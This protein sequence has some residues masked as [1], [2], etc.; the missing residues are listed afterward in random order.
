MTKSQKEAAGAIVMGVGLA[1]MLV[2]GCSSSDS[3]SCDTTEDCFANETCADGSCQIIEDSQSVNNGEGNQSTNYGSSA[4][5]S[6][7]TGNDDPSTGNNTDDAGIDDS[8]TDSSSND[9][10]SADTSTEND[11]NQENDDQ[12]QCL[13][14]PGCDRIVDSAVTSAG[15][16]IFAPDHENDAVTNYGCPNEVDDVDFVGG[17]P[18]PVEAHTCSDNLHLYRL[19]TEQCNDRGFAVDIK[20]SPLEEACPVDE[21]ATISFMTGVSLAAEECDSSNTD[22]CYVIEDAPDGSQRWTIYFEEEWQDAKYRP[23]DIRVV[24]ND[25]Y[26]FPY[27]MTIDVHEG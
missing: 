9:S 12:Q 18:A 24:P 3:V 10:S 5:S 8:G 27:E 21:L 7:N 25:D 26:S 22:Q 20:I 15:G 6:A 4:N 19:R 1:L 17:G 2:A 13:R 16:L 11:G 14:Q 23:V